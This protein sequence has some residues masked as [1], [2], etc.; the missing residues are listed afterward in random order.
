MKQQSKQYI[1]ILIGI[2]L[3]VIG[4]YLLSDIKTKLLFGIFFFTTG[5]IFVMICAYHLKIAEQVD[6]FVNSEDP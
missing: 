5:M 3:Y 2:L 1:G 6:K 4:Y